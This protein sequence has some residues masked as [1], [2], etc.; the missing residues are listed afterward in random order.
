MELGDRVT[1]RIK[2]LSWRPTP[3]LTQDSIEKRYCTIIKSWTRPK[4]L[5]LVNESYDPLL[6]TD[7]GRVTKNGI[8]TLDGIECLGNPFG[9]MDTDTHIWQESDTWGK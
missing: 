1:V 8:Q 3:D 2:N 6:A 7:K 9:F 4:L 5:Y